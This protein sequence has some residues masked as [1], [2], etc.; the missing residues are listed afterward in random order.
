MSIETSYPGATGLFA[1]SWGV[2]LLRGLLALFLGIMV[3][4]SPSL[5][6]GVLLLGFAVY[7]LWAR[8]EA[9]DGWP[10]GEW[11]QLS[12]HYSYYFAR[13]PELSQS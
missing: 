12:L 3:F 8:A 6:L 1:R 2:F 5:T 10:W 7:G 13:S 11:R 4:R 9:E